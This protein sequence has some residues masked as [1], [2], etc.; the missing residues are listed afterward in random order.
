MAFV[1]VANK[2]DVPAG[3]MRAFELSGKKILLAN[4]KGT[5]LAIAN[6][7]P[8][9]GKPLQGGTLEGCVVT[10]PYHKA[11]FDLRDGTN[12][13]DARLLFLKMSCKPATTFPL[14]IEQ[15]DIL[16]ELS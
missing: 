8:H 1:K 15:D 13:A 4:D 3:T 9:L 2:S 10:C 7:C 6:K 5:F 11:K 16:I 14:K 12:L